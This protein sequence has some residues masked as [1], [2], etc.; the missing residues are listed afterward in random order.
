MSVLEATK[1]I[2]VETLGLDSRSASLSAATPLL[3][4]MP[5]MDSL[6]VVQLAGALEDHFGITID[7][8]DFGS[9]LFATIGSL[10][11]YVEQRLGPAGSIEAAE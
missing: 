11:G 1:T 7:D 9:E 8:E 10:A 2:I 3:G 4:S 6:A 5:E